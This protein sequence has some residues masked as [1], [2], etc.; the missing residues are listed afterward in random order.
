LCFCHGGVNYSPVGEKM[1]ENTKTFALD[2]DYIELCNLLKLVGPVNSGGEAKKA[3][4]DGHVKVDGAIETRKKCKIRV[5]QS[6]E[7]N[8][9]NIRVVKH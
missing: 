8:Q 5:G 6:V 9:F 3:I 4:V 7:I 2:G 1:T